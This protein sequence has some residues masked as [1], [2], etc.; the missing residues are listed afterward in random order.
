MENIIQDKIYLQITPERGKCA[1][2]G[3]KNRCVPHYDGKGGVNGYY[4]LCSGHAN[5]A[6]SIYGSR[7][8]FIIKRAIYPDAPNCKVMGCERKAVAIGW[9][10][11]KHKF[12]S[13]CSYHIAIKNGKTPKVI[14]NQTDY[15]LPLPSK[16]SIVWRCSVDGCNRPRTKCLS[17][18]CD[19]HA[20]LHDM[21][22]TEEV[23]TEKKLKSYVQGK[24]CIVGCDKLTSSK[25]IV[26]GRRRYDIHCATHRKDR[27]R[28][29]PKVVIEIN[30]SKC[31]SCGWDGPCDKHRV[32]AGK[33]G[34]RYV[35][36]NVISLCP[37]C[38]RLT[39][40]GI[41]NKK[42]SILFEPNIIKMLA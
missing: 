10:S 25:G 29:P 6:R 8:K 2:S 37:N 16:E 20:K 18:R 24:C 33:D 42:R 31:S 7:N 17:P 1:V 15:T 28:K 12:S 26:N 27:I 34:G 19:F 32:V 3:C 35:A 22:L 41:L 14:H 30:L 21:G 38:H 36:S 5:Q 13:M 39:H 40:L 23:K 4:V 11:G 9:E